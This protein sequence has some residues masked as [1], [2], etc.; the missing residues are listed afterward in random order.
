MLKINISDFLNS[1]QIFEVNLAHTYIDDKRHYPMINRGRAHSGLLF[2]KEGNEKYNFKDKS[3]TAS[4]CSILFIPK[5]EAYTIELMGDTS[6][7]ICIDFEFEMPDNC[8][9]FKVKLDEISAINDLFTTAEKVWKKKK[10]G[11][12]S[13]CMS[14][15]YKIFSLLEKQYQKAS[16]PQNYNKIKNA[17]NYL[18][19]HY[20]DGSFR[21]ETLY[22]MSNISPKYFNTLFFSHF[23][24]TP[25]EYAIN[26]KIHLAKELLDNEKYSV[27]DISDMLGYSDIYQFSKAFKKKTFLT[28]TEYRNNK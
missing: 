14:I 26:L 10:T 17:V 6:V 2:T 19:E 15:I 24:M 1:M 23:N 12:K 22:S 27:S 16:H 9:P 28:P 3:I 8:R 5:G 25:K 18:H 13:E 11:Y 7:V 20:T 4:P 21:I